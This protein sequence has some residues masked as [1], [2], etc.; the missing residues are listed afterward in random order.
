VSNNPHPVKDNTLEASRGW[1]RIENL[2]WQGTG[3]AICKNDHCAIR[4]MPSVIN[5]GGTPALHPLIQRAG[6]S[7]QAQSKASYWL[8]RMKTHSV[9]QFDSKAVEL[10]YWKVPVKS[11][12]RFAAPK[13]VPI[14]AGK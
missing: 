6:K 3:L 7:N 14:Q 11:M 8:L 12:N 4:T 10:L 2:E 5:K 1:L 13:A 9:I